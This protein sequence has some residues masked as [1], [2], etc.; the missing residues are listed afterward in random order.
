M[1]FF[2]HFNINDEQKDLLIKQGIDQIQLLKNIERFDVN[3]S[4]A[5]IGKIHL[6]HYM[7]HR[8]S[9]FN[10]FTIP[11]KIANAVFNSLNDSDKLDV[12]AYESYVEGEDDD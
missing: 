9:F 6:M 12:Y 10:C 7:D 5:P 11:G 2:S 1:D 4:K 8:G 3:D